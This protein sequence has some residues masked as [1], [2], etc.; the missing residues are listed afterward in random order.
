MLT[1]GVDGPA[2]AGKSTAIRRVAPAVEEAFG[3]KV[4]QA[5]CFVEWAVAQ[6]HFLPNLT[7]ASWQEEAATLEFYLDLDDS[8]RAA[9]GTVDLLLL[10]RTAWTLLA[11][12][13]G[14]QA[15]GLLPT[16][17]VPMSLCDEVRRRSPDRMIYLDTSQVDLERRAL[18]R[19]DFPSVLVH[20][21]FNTAFRQTMLRDVPEAQVIDGSQA[22]ESVGDAMCEAI[23]SWLE[24]P[25]G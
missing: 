5:S 10:D 11:H 1:V 24:S 8:R 20:Q 2:L 16:E 7:P 9:V 22:V 23:A 13:G 4:G 15:L 21:M 3:I 12:N 17:A 6:G 19:P 14:L 18:S 25:Y